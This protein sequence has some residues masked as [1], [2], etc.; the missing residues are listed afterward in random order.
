MKKLIAFFVLVII[1]CNV[2][3][4]QTYEPIVLEDSDTVLI[5]YVDCNWYS[6]STINVFIE[7]DTII[8]GNSYKIVNEYE[9]LYGSFYPQYNLRRHYFIREDTLTKKVYVR[10][11]NHW[12]EELFYDFSLSVGDSINLS[13]C[14]YEM[15]NDWDTLKFFVTSVD[16]LKNSVDNNKSKAILLDYKT[17]NDSISM[18]WIENIGALNSFDYK[19]RY[20]E[21]DGEWNLGFEYLDSTLSYPVYT[22]IDHAKCKFVDGF[23]EFNIDSIIVSERSS[24]PC[25]YHQSI[26]L[27]INDN[28]AISSIQIFPNPASTTITIEP[29]FSE[30]QYRVLDF[31]GRIVSFGEIQDKQVDVSDLVPGLYF[32]KISAD[33][34]SFSAKFVKE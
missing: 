33:G 20:M 21:I 2:S 13:V 4:S 3:K 19:H 27:A 9:H 11:S 30:A 28:D 8:N 16:S 31:L 1:F 24:E 15:T 17:S 7:S 26:S 34:K 23:V 22:Y 6:Y 25:D 29:D 10:Y 18:L 14:N 12:E 5:T 32:L